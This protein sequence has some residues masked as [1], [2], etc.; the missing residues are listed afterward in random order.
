M[1]AAV[2]AGVEGGTW[3]F[4]PSRKVGRSAWTRSPRRSPSVRGGPG[5][6]L[7][8]A[9]GEARAQHRSS[10]PRRDP[11]AGLVSASAL[12][13]RVAGCEA[14]S[15]EREPSLAT[16]CSPSTAGSDV[17]EQRIFG[18]R[19]DQDSSR[20]HARMDLERFRM[21]GVSIPA[22]V[23]SMRPRNLRASS[24]GTPGTRSAWIWRS[25]SRTRRQPAPSVS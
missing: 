2:R 21:F 24:L 10:P 3:G 25:M 12:V 13:G 1:R 14:P 5:G 4:G 16:R 22:M 9:A 18:R 8:G 11:A 20:A 6:E 15:L 7:R 19:R 23:S 17:G